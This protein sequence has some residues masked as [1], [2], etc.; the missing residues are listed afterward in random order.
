MSYICVLLPSAGQIRSLQSAG[1][2]TSP[3]MVVCL[4]QWA[5]ADSWLAELLS[6]T[7]Q[8]EGAL[9]NITSV[10]WLE[11]T[12]PPALILLIY[13]YLSLF[14]FNPL[15]R[16]IRFVVRG[17]CFKTFQW[18]ANRS[19]SSGLY[20]TTLKQISRM[21]TRNKNACFKLQHLTFLLTCHLYRDMKPCW[22]FICVD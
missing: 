16:S 11:Y 17:K 2:A 5:G 18:E 7:E 15:V 14:T 6:I 19:T 13:L 8:V 22:W 21:L 3:N 4:L 20:A 1:G 12:T 10:H 9:A